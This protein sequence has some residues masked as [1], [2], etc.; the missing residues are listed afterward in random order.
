MIDC[1]SYNSYFVLAILSNHK[2]KKKN[3]Y[4]Y[5]TGWSDRL[6]TGPQRP[7]QLFK[8]KT[9]IAKFFPFKHKIHTVL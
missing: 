7:T 6:K 2:T 9:D 3:C 1:L 4:L 5:L 8:L